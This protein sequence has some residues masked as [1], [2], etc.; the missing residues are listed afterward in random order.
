MKLTKLLLFIPICILTALPLTAEDEPVPPQQMEI[1]FETAWATMQELLAANEIQVISENRGQ[2]YIKT[3]FKEYASGLLTKSHL[4]KIAVDTE[5]SDGSYD[6][7]EYQYEIE[8]RLVSERMTI[9]TVDANIRALHRNFLGE[10]K[11]IKLKSNGRREEFLLNSFG[12]IL[13]GE[14]WEMEYSKERRPKKRFVLP[15]DLNERVAS[16]ERP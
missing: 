16:P 7:V 5:T 2:G 13:W 11:W 1:P 8:I 14:D 9:L 4:E 6:K 15:A 12:K 3:G 10:E